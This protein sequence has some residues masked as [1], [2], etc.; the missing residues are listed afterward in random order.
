MLAEIDE[1]GFA[2]AV[3]P[4]DRPIF[5]K[6]EKG[7]PRPMHKLEVVLHDGR[8]CVRKRFRGPTRGM[9]RFGRIK[10]TLA[11]QAKRHAWSAL[12]IWFYVEAAALLRMASL[13][14]VPKLRGLDVRRHE[15]FMDYLP[16]DSLRQLAAAQGQPVYDVDVA[17][18]VPHR[19]RRRRAHR[20]RGAPRR[21]RGP[22]QLPR[23]TSGK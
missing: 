5:N 8:I 12:G 3:N 16:G 18:S 17:A 4:E 19:P 15:V 13:P 11:D 7:R 14:F 21:R 9:T 10:L 20:P 1:E 2:F 6:R 22:R 23:R